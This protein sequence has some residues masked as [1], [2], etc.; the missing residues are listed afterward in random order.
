MK[1]Y[2]LVSKRSGEAVRNQFDIRDGNNSYFQSYDSLI[3]KW[4]GKNLTIGRYW[5]YSMTTLKYFKQWMEESCYS[6]YRRI[7]DRHSGSFKKMIQEA[8]SDGEIVYDDS[9]E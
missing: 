9:M 2:N 6:M 4:N 5:D 7:N 8:I 1:V 3:A